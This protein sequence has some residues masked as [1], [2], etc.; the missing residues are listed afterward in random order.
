MENRQRYKDRTNRKRKGRET[1]KNTYVHI[2]ISTQKRTRNDKNTPPTLAPQPPSSLLPNMQDAGA[3]P[4]FW[5]WALQF[6][7]LWQFQSGTGAGRN[8]PVC[9]VIK[10]NISGKKINKHFDRVKKRIRDRHKDDRERE[11]IH[12]TNT[13]QPEKSNKET[14]KN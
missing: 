8:Y 11:T 13:E 1:N 12:Q 2:C 10:Q 4:R 6:G 14:K 9:T 7:D 3:T 5:V